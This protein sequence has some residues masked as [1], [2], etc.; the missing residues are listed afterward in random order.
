VSPEGG[1]F[2]GAEPCNDGG[3]SK[4]GGVIAG[5]VVGSVAGAVALGAIGYIFYM[6][7]R[8]KKGNP[9]FKPSTRETAVTEMN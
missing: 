3:S 7:G 4:N 1:Y 2:P 9:V 5:A 8:E 6:R